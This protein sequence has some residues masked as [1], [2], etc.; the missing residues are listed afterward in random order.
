MSKLSLSLIYKSARIFNQWFLKSPIEYSKP[1]SD[2]LKVPIIFKCEY[3]QPSGSFK[4]RGAYFYLSQ[5]TDQQKKQGIATCCVGNHGMSL[6]YAAYLLNIPCHLYTPKSIPSFNK[7]KF[8]DYYAHIHL[9]ST[10]SLQE[11]LLWAKQQSSLHNYHFLSSYDEDSLMAANGGSL[12]L[13]I[14]KDVPQI[15]NCI[16]PIGHGDMLSG[17]SYFMKKKYPDINIIGCEHEKIASLS[18]LSKRDPL[19]SDTASIP[20]LASELSANLSEKTFSFL[21]TRVDHVTLHPEEE[22]LEG[23]RWMLTHHQCLIDPS[24]AIVIAACLN[25]KL[26]LLEGPTVVVLGSKNIDDLTL[27]RNI[28]HTS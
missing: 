15:K 17:L 26:P 22:I 2:L 14:I 4:V 6:A 13:E 9:S 19:I 12:A 8:L 18:R 1:L 11:T 3:L 10:E 23:V 21:K 7:K 27:K 16:L 25:H 28:L 5:L 20:T 24:S